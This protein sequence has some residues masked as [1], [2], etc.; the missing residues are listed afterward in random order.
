MLLDKLLSR[1]NV[2]VEPFALCLLSAGWRLR[3]PGP[4][5]VMLHFVLHGHGAVRGPRDDAHQLAPYWFAV[6]PRGAVHALESDG[7]VQ[8]ERCI[9]APR[10]GA[11][12][13]RLIAGSPQNPALIVACGIVRV[14]YGESLG[15]FDH[16]REVLT[17]DLANVPLVHTAFQGIL[18]E[19]SR[20]GPGSEAMTAAL[21]SQCLV[22]LFRRLCG[23]SDCP[24][25]WL[26][27]LK[28]ARLARVLDRILEDPAAEHTVGS[29][30]DAESMSRSAFAERF[31]VAFGRAPMSLVH[32]VRMQRAAHLLRQGNALSIHEVADRVGFSSRSHL[33]RA[34]K[35]HFGVSSTAYRT[36]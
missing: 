10:E 28:D 33:S 11:T 20:P 6:V 23:E 7:D 9:E 24:L 34:F 26:R 4:P 14:R 19:Q 21:M 30:A 3:L 15:L 2:H 17:V 29:L 31:A 35:E 25:P 18:V 13:P 22:H 36:Q 16:L 8:H 5:D 1:L 32:H 27:V 12:V